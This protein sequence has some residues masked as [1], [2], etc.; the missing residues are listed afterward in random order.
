MY[1][2]EG[3]FD[4]LLCPNCGSSDTISYHYDEGFSELECQRCGYRSDFQE[5]SDLG[6]YRGDL[7]EKPGEAP[8][9]PIKPLE[10]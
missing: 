4:G 1:D 8:I 10:A 6:R 5:L 2:A 9:I 3:S 7:K